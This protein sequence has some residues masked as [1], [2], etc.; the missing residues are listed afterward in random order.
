MRK[1]FGNDH[2]SDHYNVD[3][4]EWV[5]YGFGMNHPTIVPITD[6][7]RRFGEITANLSSSEEIL[8]TKGGELFAV[9]RAAAPVKNKSLLELA[10]AWKGTEL[11]DDKFWK[12]VL[13]RKSRKVPISL[14]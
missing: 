3:I 12:K 11:A 6:L 5:W 10:G 8:L 13:K 4:S 1:R 14:E 2:Y 7:R 9:L